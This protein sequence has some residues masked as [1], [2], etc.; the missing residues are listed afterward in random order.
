[1][2]CDRIPQNL[3]TYYNLNIFILDANQI[4]EK[5]HELEKYLRD[6]MKCRLSNELRL[7]TDPENRYG[8]TIFETSTFNS[9]QFSQDIIQNQ[10]NLFKFIRRLG[11]EGKVGT[12]YVFHYEGIEHI[13][14]LS[15]NIKLYSNL[16]KCNMEKCTKKFKC[17]AAYPKY[18]Q[19]IPPI[20]SI[21][22][23]QESSEYINE[24]IIGYILNSI[25]FPSLMDEK[26]LDVSLEDLLKGNLLSSRDLGNSVFQSGF[27]QIR[28]G[29]W[30]KPDRLEGLNVMEKADNT[31]DKL[32]ANGDINHVIF[33][34]GGRRISEP[35]IILL[36]LLQQIVNMLEI[37]TREHG[38]NHGDLKAGNVFY[39]ISDQYM[40][41][42]YPLNG[43]EYKC[44]G[45]EGL[46]CRTNIR[47]KVADYGKSSMT[48]NGIRYFCDE[49]RVPGFKGAYERVGNPAEN[50]YRSV[51]GQSYEFKFSKIPGAREIALRHSGCPYFYSADFYVLLASWIIACPQIL[52]VLRDEQYD[53]IYT[54]LFPV[55]FGVPN[56]FD[57]ENRSLEIK[58]LSRAGK[59]LESFNTA[60]DTLDGRWFQCDAVQKCSQHLLKI[61]RGL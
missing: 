5:G 58:E 16:E 51:N 1:M 20:T 3:K 7:L 46:I 18:D 52:E 56:I 6:F 13:F 24:T 45:K 11:P 36:M 37:L 60:L 17:L 27:G 43:Y 41:V 26:N 40:T 29:S 55:G 47:L 30:F 2:S 28:S 4:K 33:E 53:F 35:E 57:M 48:Y 54:K 19:C 15:K 21:K 50:S 25:F 9:K 59:R 8:D 31:L 10:N 42:D 23:F 22:S 14:K 38:F 39:K 61:F 34:I 44:Q 49:M 32:V 12:P